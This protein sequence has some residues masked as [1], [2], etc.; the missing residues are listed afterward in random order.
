[1]TLLGL[2]PSLAD[3]S[4]GGVSWMPRGALDLTVVLWDGRV[5]HLVLE[6]VL[7]FSCTGSHLQ[8]LRVLDMGEDDPIGLMCALRADGEDTSCAAA[9]LLEGVDAFVFVAVIAPG[10][11]A[12]WIGEHAGAGEGG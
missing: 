6:Q 5:V 2:S 10:G 12:K 1:M 4:I 3:G 11:T 8:S 7:A 9:V